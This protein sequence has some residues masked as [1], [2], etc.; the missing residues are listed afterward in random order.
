M[1]FD[2]SSWHIS[3]I[4]EGKTSYLM[5]FLMTTTQ[6]TDPGIKGLVTSVPSNT[7]GMF[8]H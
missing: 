5:V 4:T 2:Q 8:V 6:T 1:Q 3:A 7:A